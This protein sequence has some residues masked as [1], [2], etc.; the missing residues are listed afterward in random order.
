[1][2]EASPPTVICVPLRWETHWLLPVRG[3]SLW[4]GNRSRSP[5]PERNDESHLL[6]FRGRLVCT[7]QVIRDGS[8]MMSDLL[9]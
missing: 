4:I 9:A 8:C 3:V 7:V 5:N 6:Q 1:M 2:T